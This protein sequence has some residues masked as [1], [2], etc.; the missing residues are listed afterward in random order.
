MKEEKEFVI[1]KK[2]LKEGKTIS[3]KIYIIEQLIIGDL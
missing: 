3:E 2:I 1:V